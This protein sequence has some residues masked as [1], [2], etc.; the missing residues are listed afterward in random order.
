[1]QKAFLVLEES[2][3]VYLL[4]VKYLHFTH[5]G[6]ALKGARRRKGL[7]VIG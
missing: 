2:L 3:L 6:S 4:I 5:G 1:M 7:E